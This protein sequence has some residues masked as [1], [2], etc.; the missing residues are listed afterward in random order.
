VRHRDPMATFDRSPRLW[1][2]V[3]L[4]PPLENGLACA[5]GQ[6]NSGTVLGQAVQTACRR[7]RTPRRSLVVVVTLGT[8]AARLRAV[9][10]QHRTVPRR[11]VQN[12]T[13]RAA[14][15]RIFARRCFLSPHH[16][17]P[18]ATTDDHVTIGKKSCADRTYTNNAPKSKKQL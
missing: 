3:R 1:P 16:Q 15:H 11:H 8:A 7:T 13:M 10:L 12:G 2:S 14:W 9:Y 5:R 18:R 17:H 6:G 4:D